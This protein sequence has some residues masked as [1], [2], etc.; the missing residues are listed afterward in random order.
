MCELIVDISSPQ[1]DIRQKALKLTANSM[2]GCLGFTHSRFYA[3]PIAALITSM[4]RETLQRTVDI[5][6]NT[7]GLDVIYGDTDSIMINTRIT[8]PADYAK[9]LVLGNKV[10]HEVNR[11]YKTLELEIDGTFRSMLLLKK[12]KYAAVTAELDKD[13]KLV[14]DKEMKGLD[15]V[16][17]DWCIQSK[18]TGRYVLDQILSGEESEIVVKRI[19]DHLEE[20]AKKMRNG[21]LP[22]EKYI[23]TKGLNKHP[24]D[25][26]DGKSQ[27]HVQVAKQMLKNDRPVNSG[28][29]IPYIITAVMEGQEGKD[30]S[31]AERARHPDEIRRSNGALKPDIEWY[32]TQQILPPTA[33]LCDPIAGTSVSNMAEKLGL[34]SSKYN[35]MMKSSGGEIDDE[36]LVDYTPSSMLP[37]EERFKDVEKLHL[38]CGE[39]GVNGEFHGIFHQSKDPSGQTILSSGLRCNNPGCSKP[40]FWGQKGHVEVLARVSN[41]V[42]GLV[43]RHMKD[44]YRGAVRCDDP[45]CTQP[46]T[47]Q[48]SVAG[49]VCLQK[50][51][52][53]RVHPKVTERAMHNQLKYLDSL[54]DVD[55][56]CDQLVQQKHPTPKN[57]L[58]KS[59]SK[60]EM[61][62][63][64][65]LHE[66]ANKFMRGSAFNWI[67]S[68][69]WSALFGAG[70]V[71]TGASKKQ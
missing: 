21:E 40:D 1:L 6:T 28:D 35:Q 55:H 3:H 71:A 27:A 9:V 29:H 18:D 25:Y 50:G 2:Y 49:T 64:E 32:L 46:E 38:R 16:R 7:V 22:L 62:T 58:L 11:L 68:S 56:A 20:L 53:G 65:E 23:I 37:D 13:G 47:C 67:E 4:G 26:P 48:V 63:M 24:N 57:E 5:A 43:Y 59:V 15:L 61:A 17:R 42:S 8:D 60:Y 30:P 34:D 66:T 69:M 12:K 14:F 31:A 70:V 44:Y 19:H 45:T 51:C 54:F 33:R 36:E 52:N 41:A 10:K 39:C